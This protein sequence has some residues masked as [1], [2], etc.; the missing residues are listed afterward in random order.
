MMPTAIGRTTEGGRQA[1]MGKYRFLAVN[2]KVILQLTI[3][4]VNPA[5]KTIVD[6]ITG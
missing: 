3:L 1:A 2:Q 5:D 6:V 4:I